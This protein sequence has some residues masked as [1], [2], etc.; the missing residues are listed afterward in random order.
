MR[1]EAVRVKM[2]RLGLEVDKQRSVGSRLSTTS[3]ILPEIKI[4]S[5]H[6][7]AKPLTQ[8][9]TILFATTFLSFSTLL[10]FCY[11]FLLTDTIQTEHIAC[12]D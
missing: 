3:E 4:L 6:T 5:T 2:K 7:R 12:I 11:S 10:V 8:P 1:P 9:I